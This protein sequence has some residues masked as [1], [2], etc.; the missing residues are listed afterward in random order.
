MLFRSS[1]VDALIALI[2]NGAHPAGD[3]ALV[4][5]ELI[6]WREAK[7]PVSDGSNRGD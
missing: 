3:A 4:V 6:R 1:T 5:G 2:D 7:Y